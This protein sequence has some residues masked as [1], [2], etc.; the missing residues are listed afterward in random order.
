MAIKTN[1][2]T[3]FKKKVLI[4]D[5]HP[6]FR[7]GITFCIN[8]EKDM[9]VCG[10]AEHAEDAVRLIEEMMPDLVILD[11]SL[12]L[13]SGLDLI[14]T[15]KA[16]NDNLPIL[17]LSMHDESL[18]AER[19]LRAGA[20]GYVMKAEASESIM[21]A[22]RRIFDGKIYISEAMSDRMLERQVQKTPQNENALYCLSDRELEVYE[23]IGR[24]TP[25]RD[26]AKGLHLSVKTVETYR[27]N[28]KEKLNLKSNIELI[29]H[30]VQWEQNQNPS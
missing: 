29:R 13:N 28:I 26:I 8:N 9:Q 30:A 5:D 6:L 3:D 22:I 27:S 15:I 25:T 1:R 11:L 23:L 24:G 19:V 21:T 2:I 4:V 16:Q 12:K 17:V 7:N 14:K 10:E 20:K 18:Y